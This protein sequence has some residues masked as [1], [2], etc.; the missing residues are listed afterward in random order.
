MKSNKPDLNVIAGSLEGLNNYLFNFTQSAEEG[1]E[2]AK[3]I[4]NY[5]KQA[6]LVN[7]DD[8]NRYAMP[9]G[10]FFKL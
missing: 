5:T 4:F 7:T 3:Y 1:S 6:L 8:V 2:H 10:F 9:R